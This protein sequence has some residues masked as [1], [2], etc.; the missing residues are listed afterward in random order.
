MQ[1]VTLAIIMGLGQDPSQG[2]L[3]LRDIAQDLADEFPLDLVFASYKSSDDEIDAMLAP[4]DSPTQP[5]ILTGHSLGGGQAHETA[6]RR[7]EG[8][9]RVDALGLWEPVPEDDAFNGKYRFSTVPG[10]PN[11]ICMRVAGNFPIAWGRRFADDSLNVDLPRRSIGIVAVDHAAMC[12]WPEVREWYAETVKALCEFQAPQRIGPKPA[13]VRLV[14][15][16]STPKP[17]SRKAAPKAKT[18]KRKIG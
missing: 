8:G 15:D 3:G 2:C 11:Q 17:R 18:R 14:S 10:V 13:R 12:E 4:F 7:I 5:T 6:M 9:L 16:T 1:R